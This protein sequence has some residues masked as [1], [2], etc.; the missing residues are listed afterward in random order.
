MVR[1]HSVEILVDKG[2]AIMGSR[3][4]DSQAIIEKGSEVLSKLLK[5]AVV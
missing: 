2:E 5:L 4:C 3:M 1:I